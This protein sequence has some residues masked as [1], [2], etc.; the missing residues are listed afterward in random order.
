[1]AGT[2]RFGPAFNLEF[3]KSVLELQDKIQNLGQAENAG[4]E[5]ICFAPMTYEGER[6]TLSQCTVQSVF[7]FFKN[8]MDNLNDEEIDSDGYVKNYLNKLAK[9]LS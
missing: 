3:L 6:P 9:C 4:L 7:G 5:H 2:I 8:L 1:M